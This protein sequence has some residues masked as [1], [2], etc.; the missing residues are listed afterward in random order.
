MKFNIL[1][2]L[3]LNF[4]YS[5]NFYKQAGLCLETFIKLFPEE[6]GK[7]RKKEK[8]RNHGLV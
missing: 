8:K 3:S 7:Q 1:T 2:G 4:L 6:K 5:I